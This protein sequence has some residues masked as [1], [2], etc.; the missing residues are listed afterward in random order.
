MSVDMVMTSPPYWGLRDYSVA[1]Q[2]GLEPSLEDYLT[3]LLSVFD[4]IKRVLK[5]TGSVYVVLGNT[6]CAPGK[7]GGATRQSIAVSRDRA[8][9][10]GKRPHQVVRE[11]GWVR[12][13][14]LA[15]VPSRFAIAMQERGWILRNGI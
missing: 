9:P 10:V 12:R 15:L 14:Q 1:G 13:K 7:W 11:H 5:P 6:Y 4:E 3:R 8:Y 2:L